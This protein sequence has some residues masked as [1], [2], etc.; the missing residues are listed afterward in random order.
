MLSCSAQNYF[1]AERIFPN[2]GLWSSFGGCLVA[3][4]ANEQVANEIK[5]EI[6]VCSECKTSAEKYLKMKR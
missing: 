1:E 6:E 4:D 2:H 5:E 3:I